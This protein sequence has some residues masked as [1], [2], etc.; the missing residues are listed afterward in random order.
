[1]HQLATFIFSNMG[2]LTDLIPSVNK[3]GALDQYLESSIGHNHLVTD[4]CRLKILLVG[5]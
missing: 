4:T 5:T 2:P 3:D 1:M